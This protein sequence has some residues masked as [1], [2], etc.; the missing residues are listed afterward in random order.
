[1]VSFIEN[2][3]KDV[4][5]RSGRGAGAADI[6][7]FAI[8]AHHVSP[9]GPALSTVLQR[10]RAAGLEAGTTL[11]PSTADMPERMSSVDAMAFDTVRCDQ[12]A[13]VGLAAG[14]RIGSWIR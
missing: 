9:S 11:L 13:C 8:T 5:L 4:E 10:L 12:T 6:T 2:H 3:H 14:R 7:A 1:M